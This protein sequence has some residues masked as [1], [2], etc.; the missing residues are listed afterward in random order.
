MSSIRFNYTTDHHVSHRPPGRRQGDYLIDL[1][2]KMDQVIAH[3]NQT[4]SNALFGGDLFHLKD[5]SKTATHTLMKFLGE[6]SNT[7]VGFA[8]PPLCAIGN[9]DIRYDRLS[10]LPEQPLGLLAQTGVVELLC[11]Y[12]PLNLV[13]WSAP[14]GHTYLVEKVLSGKAFNSDSG[15]H[16]LVYSTPYIEDPQDLL[17]YLA[18]PIFHEALGE[19]ARVSLPPATTS[20]SV[21][22]VLLLHTLSGPLEGEFFG[23]M[24]ASYGNIHKALAYSALGRATSAVLFGHEHP[25]LPDH[26]LPLDAITPLSL[27]NLPS[28]YLIA[29]TGT[30][31]INPASFSRS[32]LDYNERMEDPERAVYMVDLTYTP[33][34]A[35]LSLNYNKLDLIV[36]PITQL[37][38]VSNSSDPLNQD[39]AELEITELPVWTSFNDALNKMDDVGADPAQYL[40]E[41]LKT[42]SSQVTA[43]VKTLLVL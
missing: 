12:N 2:S 17:A 26:V 29:T 7:L 3:C 15:S 21:T 30:L 18:S 39:G 33:N 34:G 4:G 8:S 37:F 38:G 24:R 40:T 25:E 36:R 27:N 16:A 20:Q 42:E 31:Y 19:F 6:L 28:G 13:D 11:N 43:T 10:T 5:P 35:G 23:L 9:H 32:S 1:T 14:S 22:C 41:R